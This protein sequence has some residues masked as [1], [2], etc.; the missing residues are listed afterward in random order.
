M[1]QAA[2]AVL[3]DHHRAVHDDA[4]VERTQTHEIGAH[5]LAHHAGEGEEHGERNHHRGDQGRTDV[6]QKQEQHRH[7]EQR[8]LGQVLL[9]RVDGAV[10]QQGAVVDRLGRHARGQALGDFLHAQVH[11]AR[12]DS[13]VLA[14]QHEH[15]A[16]H[17][18]FTVLGGRPG[19]Q[20]LPHEHFGHVA[21]AQR[22][23]LARGHHDVGDVG[24]AQ[25]P[26]GRADQRLLTAALDV[27]GADAGVVALERDH[28]VVEREAVRHELGGVGR[29]LEILR[30]AADG[31]DLG[32]AGHGA[33]LRLDD[34]VLD[35]AQ[36]GRRVGR[37][38]G[39]L[40][41][42]L[43]AHRPHVDLA[44]AGG[45]GPQG[46][47][48]ARR[49]ALGGLLHALVDELAREVDVGAFLEDHRH[50]RQAVARDR[51]RLLQPRQPGHRRL[52]RVGDALLDLERRVAGRGGVDL[53]LHVGDVG[54]RVDG[55]AQGVVGAE[56]GHAE[57]RQHHEPAMVDRKTNQFVEHA[58]PQ[59]SW[60]APALPM[61][62]L[63]RKLFFV[64]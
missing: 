8:A 49:Q 6:A 44:Q 9:H 46:R 52:H 29:D 34:P 1:R 4:E 35:F 31:V 48:D 59:W 25:H 58:G 23:A 15:G 38:V 42:G 19:A 51:A 22:H 55:Q 61:S 53:H 18:F 11:R 10:H 41:A 32:D 21:H 62:A 63:M 2:H 50:L 14:D 33:Q 64:A 54:H 43:G 26:P 57:H 30:V 7:H 12:D 47:G 3:H 16:E 28:H 39:L 60:L 36:V 24:Q 40:G 20:L 5:A 27:A 37:A 13:A 45:N 17:D 56:R